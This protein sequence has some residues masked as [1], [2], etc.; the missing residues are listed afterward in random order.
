MRSPAG[1]DVVVIEA[2]RTPIGRGHPEKG[3]FK[4][5]HPNELL[6]AAFT[7]VIDR[8]GIDAAAVEDVIA[9]CVQQYG[10][11]G[12][13]IARNAWLQQGLP[14]EAA[15][16]TVGRQCG[17]AQQAVTFA[18]ALI[19][20]GAHDVAI[21]AGVEHMGRIPLGTPRRFEADLGTPPPPKLLDR[22]PLVH[23]GTRRRAD[24]RA[25]RAVALRT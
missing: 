19:A 16:V 4:D 14:V 17:S 22:H 8:S 25:V 7:A 21:G 6:G 2:A 3:A 23:Q 18:A 13:N 10:V 5:V 24:R 20:C 9:G 11:Q 12:A 15:A 1:R